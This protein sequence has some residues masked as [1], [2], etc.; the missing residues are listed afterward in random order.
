MIHFLLPIPSPENIYIKL[1]LNVEKVSAGHKLIPCGP[2]LA[3]EMQ[4]VHP[5]YKEHIFLF[6]YICLL[7]AATD[8]NKNNTT[9]PSI[10]NAMHIS[11][12]NNYVV[13]QN[14]QMILHSQGINHTQKI[15]AF[16]LI[17]TI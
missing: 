16:N 13:K 14:F 4:V 17:Q 9:K 7:S 12:Y 2:Y 10:I 5:Y 11:S 6:F 15:K 1:Q 3:R 8:E